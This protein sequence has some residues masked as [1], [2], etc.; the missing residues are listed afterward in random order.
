[1]TFEYD[2]LATLAQLRQSSPNNASL[3]EDWTNLLG[4]IG[5]DNIATEPLVQ[6]SSVK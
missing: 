1:M 6:S 3:T 4:S 5:L 2:S